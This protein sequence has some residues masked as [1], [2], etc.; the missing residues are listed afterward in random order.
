LKSTETKKTIGWREW[1]TLPELGI[2]AIK[3]KID[4]GAKTSA[5]HAFKLETF[6]SNGQEYVRFWMHPLQR[7]TDI[8]FVCVAPVAD[9]RL[10]RDSGGHQEQRYIIKTPILLNEDLWP[11]EISLTSRENMSFRMLLGRSALKHGAFLVD[12]GRSYITGRKLRKVYGKLQK[13]RIQ[14]EQT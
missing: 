14:R 13:S 7:K 11:V 6:T 8:E 3:A 9:Q 2:P 12:P 1:L 5:L 4:T 10:I